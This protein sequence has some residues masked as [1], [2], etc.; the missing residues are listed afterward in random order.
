MLQVNQDCQ[1]LVSNVRTHG[2]RGVRVPKVVKV[3]RGR[4]GLLV[5]QA[6]KGKKYGLNQTLIKTKLQI[7]DYINKLITILQITVDFYCHE[8]FIQVEICYKIVL[9]LLNNINRVQ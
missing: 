4:K 7:K 2:L 6:S 3:T 5:N 9:S 1:V 8:R